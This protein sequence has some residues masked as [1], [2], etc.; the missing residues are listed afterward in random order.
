MAS[1]VRDWMWLVPVDGNRMARSTNTQQVNLAVLSGC[2]S[3]LDAYER[4]MRRFLRIF[5]IVFTCLVAGIFALAIGQFVHAWQSGAPHDWSNFSESVRDV[6]GLSPLT[7]IAL[8]ASIQKTMRQGRLALQARDAAIA[9]NDYLAPVSDEQPEPLSGFELSSLPAMLGP[10]RVPVSPRRVTLIL[11]LFCFL[12]S[13]ALAVAIVAALL[14]P[15]PISSSSRAFIIVLVL[16]VWV[17]L[18]VVGAVVLGL[19]SANASNTSLWIDDWEFAWGRRRDARRRM[20]WSEAQAFSKWT[21][22][23]T[24]ART[25]VTC[26]LA[27]ARYSS[28]TRAGV[29]TPTR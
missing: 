1:W 8:P 16:F 21:I 24:S 17:I 27:R 3:D 25:P 22:T 10:I 15:L 11:L 29:Q 13:A 9:G 5:M 14:L 4:Y 2:V 26:L 6:L 18:I 23:L 28:G 7:L 12:A 19:R 20:A